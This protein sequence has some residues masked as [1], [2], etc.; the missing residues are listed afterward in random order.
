[1]NLLL[2]LIKLLGI[3]YVTSIYFILGFGVAKS[4]DY[5]T[6]DF[7]EA[8]ENKKPVWQILCEILLRLCILGILIYVARNIVRIVPFPLDGMGGFDYLRLKE[9]DNEFIFTIP[10]FVY[11]TNFNKKIMN[12]YNRL[13]Q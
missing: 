2:L 3:S 7:N 8:D 11:H 1:M 6:Q 10:I 5:V 12:L 13:S 9:L 4:L